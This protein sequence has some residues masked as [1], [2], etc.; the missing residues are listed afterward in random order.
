MSHVIAPGRSKSFQLYH[1][2]AKVA[3]YPHS[4]KMLRNQIATA[5]RMARHGH[6]T[7]QIRD[8]LGLT[9]EVE[10]FRR[11]L[12]KFNI[13]PRPPKRPKRAAAGQ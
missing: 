1:T 8:A 7:E 6:T 10:S 12:K 2:L 4:A 13:Q 3:P 11:E 5:H 9:C